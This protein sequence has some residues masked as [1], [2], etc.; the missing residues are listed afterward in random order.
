MI[1]VKPLIVKLLNTG[2]RRIIVS[3]I[4]DQQDDTADNTVKTLVINYEM[5]G[6]QYTVKGKNGESLILGTK[7]PKVNI[8]NAK[9]DRWG[10]EKETIDIQERLQR[11]F[12][13]G[14]NNFP[15]SWLEQP[16]DPEPIRFWA[17]MFEYAINGRTGKWNG[18]SWNGT[19]GIMISIDENTERVVVAP[20]NDNNGK[21][22]VDFYESGKYEL[23]FASNKKRTETVS[24][25]EPLNL[26]N[27]WN[28]TF[29]H[30]TVTFDKLMSWNESADE[31]IKYFS[32][33]ATYTK[34]FSIPENFQKDGMRWILDLGQVEMMAQIELN[35]KDFGVLWK[36]EKSIDVTKILKTGEN[37]LKISVTNGWPNRLIGDAQLPASDERN[38]NGT[39]KT[40][41]QWL[42]DGKSDPNGRS[43]F[44]IQNLWKKDDA[45]VPSG[46][47]G[48]VRLLPVKRIVV[49]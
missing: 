17:L 10:T 39:L 8:L 31:S 6:K 14:E 18:N 44:C 35:G 26:N 7:L 37:Q 11:Y 27:N 48:Q 33:T 29:P 46:L 34:T 41:P 2:E 15:V 5:N 22:C 4:D 25:P 38:E 21:S 19:D 42:L 36:V 12:D 30:R 1:D 9:Y 40:W 16:D 13:R 47:I 24:L 32:G 3:R 20:V 49:E 23:T 45:L 43:T 28:V